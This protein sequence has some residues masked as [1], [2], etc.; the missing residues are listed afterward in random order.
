MPFDFRNLVANNTGNAISVPVIGATSPKYPPLWFYR[1]NKTAQPPQ[2]G[3]HP[4]AVGRLVV[5]EAVPPGLVAMGSLGTRRRRPEQREDEREDAEDG[6]E[7]TCGH[8]GTD[9]RRHG[10]LLSAP[11]R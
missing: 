2:S 10:Q 6:D 3:V 9:E 7:E 5:G 8:G 11:A 4:P 1:S